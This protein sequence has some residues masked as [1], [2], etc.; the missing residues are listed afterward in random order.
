MMILP[1]NLYLSFKDYCK[2]CRISELEIEEHLIYGDDEVRESQHI[3]TCKHSNACY[4]MRKKMLKEE[5]NVLGGNSEK[6]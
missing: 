6:A 5:G 3:L 1:K 4:E 2:N